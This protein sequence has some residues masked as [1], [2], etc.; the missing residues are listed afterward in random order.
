MSLNSFL[1]E[2]LDALMDNP[3]AIS[4]ELSEPLADIL[5]TLNGKP[6][7]PRRNAPQRKTHPV[8]GKSAPKVTRTERIYD[9]QPILMTASQMHMRIPYQI[10][11]MRTISGYDITGRRSLEQLF[12][13]QGRFM[14]EFTDDFPEQVP[15]TR[16]MPM[17]YNLS[18]NELRCYF[19]WRTRYRQGMLPDTESPYLLLY[20]CEIINQIGVASPKK[21]YDILVQLYDDYAVSNPDF[22]KKLLSWMPD[23]AAY[24]ELPFRSMDAKDAALAVLLRHTLHTPEE[25]LEAIDALSKY[26]IMQS[27][28]YTAHPKETAGAVKA[29]YEQLLLH[30]A[31]VRHASFP[32]YLLGERQRRAHILFEGGI[33]CE[34]NPV[35]TRAAYRLTPVCTYHCY[36]GQWAV[37][38]FCGSPD[39]VRIGAFLRTLDALLREVLHFKNKLKPAAL[40]EGDANI[41]RRAILGW[42]EAERQRS[43]PKIEFDSAELDEIRRA[44]EH[45]TDLLTLPDDLPEEPLLPPP[46]ESK[47]EPPAPAEPEIPAALPLSKPALTLL[48][49]LLTDASYQP[50]IDAGQMISV[51]T[52]E[53]NEA[54]YDRF[55]DTVIDADDAG[56]PVLVPDYA[57]ELRQMI[58]NGG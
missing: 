41:I 36:G 20:A 5:D 13:Q 1:S 23:Y 42:L 10:Q 47:P 14:S 38:H 37:E 8:T 44:A 46:A 15:C 48:L 18:N 43:L 28:L 53:I 16:R 21:G 3:K 54:L 29:A 7:T 31:Q 19:T 55:G 11:Q 32:A 4:R 30:Y 34:T 39:S 17:Y 27:K 6:N 22:A 45:T 12:V 49:C 58:E 57:D 33:F 52:E 35:I 25:F 26:H 2:L 40:P 56:N 50:L 9:E 51:L 24:Y